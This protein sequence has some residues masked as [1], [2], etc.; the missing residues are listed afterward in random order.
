MRAV[1]RKAK[2]GCTADEC[3][4][5]ASM[6]GFVQEGI[7]R[8]L[9][10]GWVVWKAPA[11]TWAVCGCV[12]RL[13]RHRLVGSGKTSISV[14]MQVPAENGKLCHPYPDQI[15]LLS[16][17]GSQLSQVE[18]KILIRW[19]RDIRSPTISRPGDRPEDASTLLITFRNIRCKAP[20]KSC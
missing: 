5:T 11:K 16:E 13:A 18:C 4:K 10:R 14:L 3:W 19:M 6:D 9:A 12:W 1:A 8:C 2:K 7:A 17:Q 20:Y 15:G